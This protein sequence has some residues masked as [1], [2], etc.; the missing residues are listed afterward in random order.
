MGLALVPENPV[1]FKMEHGCF[2]SALSAGA[3]VLGGAALP[4]MGR[5]RQE[6]ATDLEQEGQVPA[7]RTLVP[8]A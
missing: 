3:T 4:R 2:P 6:Q 1:S 7:C 5:R 8:A